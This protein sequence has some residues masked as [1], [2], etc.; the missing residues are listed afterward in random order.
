MHLY[1]ENL[2]GQQSDVA[3]MIVAFVCLFIFVLFLCTGAEKRT[4]VPS[5]TAADQRPSATHGAHEPPHQCSRPG[6]HSH[7]QV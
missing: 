2:K 1:R 3:A 6:K 7:T 5:A 4:P